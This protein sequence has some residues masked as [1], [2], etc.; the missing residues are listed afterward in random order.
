MQDK[1]FLAIQEGFC[2][3]F[4]RNVGA[5]WLLRNACHFVVVFNKPNCQGSH[6]FARSW[7]H[8]H[9]CSLCG[10]SLSAHTTWWLDCR[11]YFGSEKSIIYGGGLITL[12]YA[13][14]AISSSPSTFYIGLVAVAFGTG[15]AKSQHQYHSRWAL[16]RR[17]KEKGRSIFY[18]LYGNQRGFYFRNRDG[19]LYWRKSKLAFGICNGFYCYAFGLITFIFMGRTYLKG[20]GDEPSAK[21]KVSDTNAVVHPPINKNV[22]YIIIGALVV[23]YAAL[24]FTGKIDFP[25]P[26]V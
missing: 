14:L 1:S 24:H 5:F 4:N 22:L 26:R 11:Q 16:S 15:F 8:L 9:L 20:I 2:I 3:V 6:G 7:R 10:F 13:I 25:M 23:L 19:W 18:F 21:V 12:G 17:R